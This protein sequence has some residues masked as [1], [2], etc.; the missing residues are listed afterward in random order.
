MA[1]FEH[2]Q[3]HDL[4]DTNHHNGLTG[5]E[6]NFVSLD[7][8]GGLQD[9]TKSATSF[10]NAS[11]VHSAADLTSGLIIDARV[12]SSNITQHVA[13]I[14]HNGLLNYD[15]GEHRV[16]ADESTSSIDL[17]SANKINAMLNAIT[18]GLNRRTKAIDY[19]DA[20]TA[21]PT[22]ITGDRY[23]LDFSGAPHA[24]WDGASQGDIVEFNGSTWDA[25]S[26][27]EGWVLYVDL[28]NADYLY[29][30]D[31]SPYWESRDVSDHALNTLENLVSVAIN[32]ALLPA[33]TGTIDLGSTSKKWNN[34][35]LIGNLNDGTDSLT[36]ANASFAYVNTKK[37]NYTAT[38]APGIG[39]DVTQGWS[40]GS[41]WYWGE[42]E[43]AFICM[44]PEEGSAKWSMVSSDGRVSNVTGSDRLAGKIAYYT[45]STHGG[46]VAIDYAK[47]DIE[48]TS[49]KTAGWILSTIPHNGF[50][51][52]V[53]QG[54][55]NNLNTNAYVAGT[56][57]FLSGTTAGEF[58][59][60]PGKH[61][62]IVGIVLVQDTNNGVVL[63]DIQNGQETWELHDVNST[64]PTADMQILTYNVS[65]IE[66]APDNVII[67]MKD[68]GWISW[69][70]AGNY[71]S[72]TADKFKILRSGTGRIHGKLISWAADIET[73][74]L[75]ANTANYIYVNSSGVI[76]STTTR[77]EALYEDN[78]VLFI[79]L[80][81]G[82]N[83]VVSKE[84]HP[85][86]FCPSISNYLH[87]VIGNVLEGTGAVI[88]RVT[89]GT[90]SVS[91]DR[92]IKIVGADKIEDH[93]LETDV[94]DSGGSGVT[95]NNYYTN[96]SG[97]W[98]RDSQQTQIPMKYN[99]SGTATTITV[100]RYGI[101]RVYIAKDNLNSST[102]QYFTVMHTD[103]Y[104]TPT[105]ARN[106]IVDGVAQATNEL[107]AIELAQLGY[108]IVQNNTPGGHIP[109]VEVAI[110]TLRGVQTGTGATNIAAL[111]SV[112]ATGFTGLLSTAD[113]TVQTALETIDSSGVDKGQVAIIFDGGGAVLTTGIKKVYLEIPY[114]GTITAVRLFADQVGSVVIDIWKDT[115]ANF[116]PTVA[117]TITASAKPTLTSAIKSEDTT[118]TGWTKSITKG[119]I[120]EFNIDSVS[121]ITKLTLTL[122]IDKTGG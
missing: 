108:L 112:D 37:N 16:I 99:S 47:A 62:V 32:T 41:V 82:T 2:P 15:V 31:G 80:F 104:L 51:Y 40:K 44:D 78:I 49:S 65:A 54:I 13:L 30:D 113:T 6:D 84:N 26:P 10:A 87:D 7:A 77:T 116:P 50:G 29:V 61:S 96:A 39:D 109:E 24:N 118:L 67:D 66:Y 81:D 14:N 76:G 8:S 60:V 101:F 107:Y 56:L 9:S 59:N 52:V 17:W 18:S 46:V 58:S 90:G 89:T 45:S 79:S 23:V 3:L 105:L 97:K 5:T 91:T 111:V 28:K 120:L 68:T 71:Y 98:V 11:H 122:N 57:L 102:P 27:S 20:T 42:E 53:R 70:G 103:E 25:T 117:D 21:P 48:N 83:H 12:P 121:T 74:T 110:D 55:V 36:V 73:G 95:F 35:W 33:T 22:E 93:G 106:A 69:G 1:D 72:I 92:E 88:T 34:L 43:K 64:P 115:Y 19:V 75:S 4:D 100:N 38:S 86:K 63:A 114:S 119:D 85:Y 94:P